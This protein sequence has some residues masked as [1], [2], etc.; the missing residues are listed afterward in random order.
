MRGPQRWGFGVETRAGAFQRLS[1]SH[2]STQSLGLP[3]FAAR[4]PSLR[5]LV[6]T[7]IHTC[8][9]V[10]LWE[11]WFCFSAVTGVTR[12]EGAPCDQSTM[13][14][15]G[16]GGGWGFFPAGA[17]WP[18]H[19][20]TRCLWPGP[21]PAPSTVR[22][23]QGSL[24]AD[25]SPWVAPVLWGRVVLPLDFPRCSPAVHAGPARQPA[26]KNDPFCCSALSRAVFYASP[27]FGLVAAL[28]CIPGLTAAPSPHQGWWPLHSP[29]EP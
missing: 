18:K 17:L 6:Q 1:G 13:T 7:S 9:A 24:G 10:P 20:T 21:H 14:R 8:T 22:C 27:C 4:S 25:S 12:W 26:S 29:D 23:F 28:I 5:P 3:L 2:H 15:G 11:P 16:G 19:S